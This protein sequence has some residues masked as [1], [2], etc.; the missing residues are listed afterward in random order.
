[1]TAIAVTMTEPEAQACIAA[2][3][4]HASEMGRLLIDLRDREGWRVLGYASWTQCLEQEFSFSR[5]H[6]Y[7]IMR[8]QPIQDAIADVGFTVTR[9]QADVLRRYPEP[10]RPA[11]VSIAH[12]RYE[13]K[14]TESRL[15]RVAETIVQATRSGYVDVQDG[16]TPRAFDAALTAQDDLARQQQRERLAPRTYILHAREAI[17]QQRSSTTYSLILDAQPGDLPEGEVMISIW[18]KD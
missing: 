17:G 1:M 9:G 15:E 8:A 2:I 10:L 13:G 3:N 18:K 11:I 14:L 5:K 4:H 6:L 16:D 12:S 7:E